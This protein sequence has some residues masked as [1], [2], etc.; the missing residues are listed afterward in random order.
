MTGFPLL[1]SRFN[2]RLE[3]ERYID[4]LSIRSGIKYFILI[5]PGRGYLAAILAER[6]PGAKIISLHVEEPRGSMEPCDSVEPGDF[7]PRAGNPSWSPGQ[8]SLPDFLEREIPDSEAS[9]IMIVEWR[10]AL[11]VY[12][13]AYLALITETAGFIKRA[14][15]GARTLRAFGKRWMRNF[16]RNLSIPFSFLGETSFPVPIIV[17]ASGPGLENALSRIREMKENG[18]FILAAS[19]SV[20]ALRA[21][22]VVPDMAISTDGGEWAL[23]HLYECFRDQKANSFPRTS[24]AASLYAALP[25]QCSC[26]PFLAINDGSLWQNLVLKGLGIPS[27]P[28][29]QRGTVSASALDL[30]FHLG[31]DDIFIAGMDLLVQDIR[32]HARPYSLDRIVT[33]GVSRLSPAY[34]RSFKRAL[35]IKDGGSYGVYAAWFK[36]QLG[37]WPRRIISLGENNPV[38]N[39]AELRQGRNSQVFRRG[40]MAAFTTLPSPLLPPELRAA[41]GAEILAGAL[42]DAAVSDRVLKE[43]GEIL[44]PEKEHPGVPELKEALRAIAARRKTG[45]SA[46]G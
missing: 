22:G 8:G 44:F 35:D 16:F 25:S 36:K 23:F 41:R 33:S 31:S 28:M 24:I 39:T 32:T 17:T 46:G 43:L 10:P 4:A 6:Y 11:N 45:R 20:M 2:P 5:E 29:A 42:D 14:D 34:S 21:G 37:S 18:C 15:A 3:A 40:Q 7:E 13:K 19:S 12:G 30:A 27:I 1:H 38:F 9:R 26:A